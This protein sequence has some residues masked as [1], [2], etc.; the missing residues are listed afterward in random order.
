[1]PQ[2]NSQIGRECETKETHL[3]IEFLAA[4]IPQHW[5]SWWSSGSRETPDC[6]ASAQSAVRW[7]VPWCCCCC[8]YC[9][10]P[11]TTEMYKM[12]IFEK[13]EVEFLPSAL[14]R[15][16]SPLPRIFPGYPQP[17]QNQNSGVA[18]SEVFYWNQKRKWRKP[19]FFLTV[20]RILPWRQYEMT[21]LLNVLPQIQRQSVQLQTSRQPS[22]APGLIPG[23]VA[24]QKGLGNWWLEAR[25]L[26]GR[27]WIVWMV[28]K[29]WTDQNWFWYFQ[30]YWSSKF[31]LNIGLTFSSSYCNK[32]KLFI[33]F[34]WT[35][36]QTFMNKFILG[37]NNL[38]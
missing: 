1:M 5:V 3:W 6:V 26:I 34:Y 17:Q 19:R 35:I 8:C 30:K 22:L 37:K 31:E 7:G 12:F 28:P 38:H 36:S 2:Q 16:H 20:R 25:N 14:S 10:P 27:C 4:G 13:S 32:S 23:N 29:Y 9:P 18:R 33:T 21:L 15:I 11:S 24:A